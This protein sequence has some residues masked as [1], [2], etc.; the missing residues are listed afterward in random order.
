MV[1]MQAYMQGLDA[2]SSNGDL[3]DKRSE[4]ETEL[5]LE[6]IEAVMVSLYGPDRSALANG[7]HI[8]SDSAAQPSFVVNVSLTF[9][10][11]IHL[12]LCLVRL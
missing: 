4:A 1:L 7:G 9:S 8:T 11:V 5:S 2:D 3:L 10:K 6:Q 12:D